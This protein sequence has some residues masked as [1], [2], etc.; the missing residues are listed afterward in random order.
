LSFVHIQDPNQSRTR[1]L[2]REGRLYQAHCWTQDHRRDLPH[3]HRQQGRLPLHQGEVL[4]VIPPSNRK[5]DGNPHTVHLYSIA[6]NRY[7]DNM[8]GSTGF[9]CVHHTTYWCPELQAEDPTKKGIC[10]NFLW[11]TQPGHKVKMMGSAGK[12]MIM[13]NKDPYTDY[14]MVVIGHR[15]LPQ[16]CPLPLLQGHSRH[17]RLQDPKSK[18]E[19][20]LSIERNRPRRFCDFVLIP[21]LKP[22]FCDRS[23]HLNNRHSLGCGFLQIKLNSPTQQLNFITA[24]VLCC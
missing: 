9:L 22:S 11:N 2:H 24:P 23:V 3:H 13:P 21:T 17:V 18:F 15:P 8:T 12:V 14:I 19:P 20:K 5:D 16:F 4:G 10:S 6:S 1:C 7:G